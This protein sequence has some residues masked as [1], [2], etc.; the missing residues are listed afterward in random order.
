MN[1]TNIEYNSITR[2]L[3][4]FYSN[5]SSMVFNLKD[6]YITNV[7]VNNNTQEITFIYSDN[8]EKTFSIAYLFNNMYTKTEIETIFAPMAWETF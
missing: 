7:T 6:L 5:G 8:S 1:V 3:T 4:V 2:T